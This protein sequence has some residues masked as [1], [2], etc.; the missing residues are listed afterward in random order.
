MYVYPTQKQNWET[1]VIS[2][3]QF[4]NKG[5]AEIGY[6]RQIHYCEN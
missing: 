1:D 6:R 4:E 3:Q 5:G 2:T